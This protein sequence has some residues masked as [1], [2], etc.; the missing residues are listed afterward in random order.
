M[1]NKTFS[2][3]KNASL[4]FSIVSQ[5]YVAFFIHNMEENC[6]E[7]IDQ[8]RYDHYAFEFDLAMELIDCNY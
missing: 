8:D 3:Y 5:N 4:Y 7:V 1:K 6:Y 2:H